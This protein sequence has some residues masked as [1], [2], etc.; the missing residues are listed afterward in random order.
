GVEKECQFVP[1]PPARG[2]A[3]GPNA[4]APGDDHPV[5]DVTLDHAQPPC[6][7]EGG[8][9]DSVQGERYRRASQPVVEILHMIRPQLAERHM[10]E[11]GEDVSAERTLVLLASRRR[12]VLP[13]RQPARQVLPE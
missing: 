2:V 10:T 13:T 5:E 6:A 3:A 11:C 7:V 9:Q 8:V 12:Q 4:V 1:A